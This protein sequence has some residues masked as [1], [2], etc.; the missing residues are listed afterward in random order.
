MYGR[1]FILA[2]RFP[3]FI[4]SA[5]SRR[6][7][8]ITYDR[9]RLAKRKDEPSDA[10]HCNV[11]CQERDGCKKV[12]ERGVRPESLQDPRK[13][14]PGPWRG[15]ND[16]RY[17]LRPTRDSGDLTIM[18]RAGKGKCKRGWYFTGTQKWWGQ[19]ATHPFLAHSAHTGSSGARARASASNKCGTT[20]PAACNRPTTTAARY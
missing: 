6:R 18:F 14:P 8:K 7:G 5:A 17:I 10:Y 4:F 19:M 1:Y 16:A 3:P 20:S 9:K 11:C 15:S 12:E 2:E 13:S